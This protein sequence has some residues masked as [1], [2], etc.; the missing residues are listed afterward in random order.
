MKKHLKKLIPARWRKDTKRVAVV[1]L[2]GA[3]GVGSPLRPGL[4]FQTINPAIEKAFELKGVNAVALLINSPGGSPVQSAL[5]CDRIRRLAD[6]HKVPVYVFMEDVAASG[7]YWMAMAGDEIYADANTIVGSIGVISA[8]FGFVEAI[9][10][11]GVERRV[12]TSGENKS[13]LDPFQPKKKTDIERLKSI[14]SDIHESFKDLVRKR[15]G[16]KLDEKNK[17]LFSGAFWTGN[18]AI[19]LGLIDKLGNMH[20]V[21]Q[22]KF[23]D[24]VDINYISAAK[25]GLLGRLM[26]ASD[27]ALSIGALGGL[28]EGWS[29]D[30][31][32]TLEE[33]SLWARFGL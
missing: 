6:E 10:K 23:G 15:R 26:P 28:T 33:R 14:Q 2:H 21:L 25:K 17:D 27:A 1:R 13:I 32:T 5:I 4:S 22:E 7:G 24:D 8:S 12:Q 20:Q 29:G 18:Q 16:D 11:L 3:I 31:L 19:E 30:V 9:K